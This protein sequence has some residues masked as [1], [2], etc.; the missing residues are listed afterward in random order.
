MAARSVASSFETRTRVRVAGYDLARP[1]QDEDVERVSAST[2]MPGFTAAGAD[3]I[4][5]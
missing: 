5:A 4:G 2:L 1:P 3:A